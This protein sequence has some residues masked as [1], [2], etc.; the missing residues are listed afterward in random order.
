MAARAQ[1]QMSPFNT[2]VMAEVMSS[3]RVS[4]AR[5]RLC[6]LCLSSTS[7]D[8]FASD[9]LDDSVL[10]QLQAVRVASL[11]PH[12][13]LSSACSAGRR[14]CSSRLQRR[15]LARPPRPRLSSSRPLRLRPRS[16]RCVA[17]QWADRDCRD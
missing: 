5:L 17:A 7:Q 1:R 15:P 6:L 2:K 13:V 16:R 8:E 12:F 11:A 3:A 4:D 9:G 10:Q 14:R